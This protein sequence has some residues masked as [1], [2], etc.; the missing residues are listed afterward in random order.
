[1]SVPVLKV[2]LSE[3]RM[4]HDFTSPCKAATCAGTPSLA[5]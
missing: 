3:L 5:L 1:M 4:S 2:H